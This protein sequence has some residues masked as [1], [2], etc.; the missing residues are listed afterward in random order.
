M[1]AKSRQTKILPGPLAASTRSKIF[2]S[3]RRRKKK[4]NKEGK[5]RLKRAQYEIL[6][7]SVTDSAT[8]FRSKPKVWN[9]T[10]R[11]FG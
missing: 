8:S 11:C 4:K 3:G 6:E 10:N 5:V 2:G 9:S 1:R 7:K